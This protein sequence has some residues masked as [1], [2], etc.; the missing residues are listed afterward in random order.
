MIQTLGI[1]LILV[2]AL[3]WHVAAS[4][5]NPTNIRDVWKDILA[6]MQGEAL[7]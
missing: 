2:G 6:T 5:A 1:A 4:Q 7:K 3:M